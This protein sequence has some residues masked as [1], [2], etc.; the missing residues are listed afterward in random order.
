M[1]HPSDRDVFPL[2]TIHLCSVQGKK[3]SGIAEARLL[4]LL[5]GGTDVFE[6]RHG[7]GWTLY[8]C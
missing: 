7:P 8:N 5:L 2:G 4:L 1:W 6:R 3:V